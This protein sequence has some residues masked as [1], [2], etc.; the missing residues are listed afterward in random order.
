MFPE[1]ILFSLYFKIFNYVKIKNS[2][3]LLHTHSYTERKER[4]E[5]AQQ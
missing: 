2:F 5:Y 3:L 1:N 4:K